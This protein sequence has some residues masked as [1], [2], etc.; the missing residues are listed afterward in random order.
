[1]SNGPDDEIRNIVS[2]LQRL[3]IQEA[4][5]LERL[6]RLSEADRHAS[7]PP[8]TTREFVIGDVVKIRNK[9]HFKPR[10]VQSLGLA[11]VRTE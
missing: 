10:E 7:G 6:D 11:L 4:E 9:G 5:L 2:Q 8:I 3:Q 1:M